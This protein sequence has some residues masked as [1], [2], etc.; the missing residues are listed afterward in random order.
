MYVHMC[1]HTYFQY[2]APV[3]IQTHTYCMY[4]NKWKPKGDIC[5][6]SMHFACALTLAAD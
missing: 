3:W 2:Y 6:V 1:K 4:A 5:K